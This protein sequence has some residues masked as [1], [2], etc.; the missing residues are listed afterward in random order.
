VACGA[1]DS[2]SSTAAWLAVTCQAT[3][4]AVNTNEPT[5]Y[6]CVFYQVD[7]PG[8]GQL[9]VLWLQDVSFDNVGFCFEMVQGCSE[10]FRD[11]PNFT[12][13]QKP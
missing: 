6:L 10:M 5:V 7:R 8:P 9:F 2:G 12:S 13:V 3:N 11:V 4:E 1:R